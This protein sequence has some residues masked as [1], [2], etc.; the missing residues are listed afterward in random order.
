MGVS[1][2]L[3]G[4]VDRLMFY[5][6]SGNKIDFFVV[7]VYSFTLSCRALCLGRLMSAGTCHEA[8]FIIYVCV[9]AISIKKRAQ[10]N[11]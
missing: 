10:I 1:R 9:R 8:E 3:F 7:A 2:L 4:V 5:F 11:V 6:I